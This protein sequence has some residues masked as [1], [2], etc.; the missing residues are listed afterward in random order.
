MSFVKSNLIAFIKLIARYILIV[1]NDG[2]ICMRVKKRLVLFESFNGKDVSD[3]PLAIYKKV[4]E[5]NPDMKNSC[6]FSVKPS[7]FRR[8]SQEYPKIRLLKRFTPL[9]VW[10]SARA[11]FWVMNSRMPQWWKKNKGT[12]YIQTWHGTPLKRLGVDISHVEIPGNTT[13]QYHQQ[14]IDEADRWDYLI[15][16]NAYSKTIFQSAFGFHHHF[17]DIGYPRND[18]LYHENNLKSIDL[19]KK[20]LLG[21]SPEHV[22]MY[23]PTWRDDDYQKQGVYKFELPFSLKKFFEVVDSNTTLIIRPHY[24]VKDHINIS[25]FEDRVKICAEQDIKQL[26]LITDLLI[27]DYSSVMFDFANLKRP[28]LFFPYDL[29]HYRDELRGFYFEYQPQNLPGPMVTDATR[30]YS[31]LALFNTTRRFTD[32]E[33]NLEDFN[34]KFCAWENGTASQK[35]SEIILKGMSKD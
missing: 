26:Y 8:L 2:F 30:F 23:A 11:S 27:T 32:Y 14:F 3:N 17:L 22:I 29:D 4:I 19:L 6:Y 31:E 33:K 5:D 7:A 10:Y 21:T 9:W 15:A 35:V 34:T 24:L 18:I 25:G 20:Q 16:P 13:Q 12:T 28:M 1:I